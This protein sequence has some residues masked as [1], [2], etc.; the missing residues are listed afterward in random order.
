MIV[1]FIFKN[2]AG[3]RINCCEFSLIK[4]SSGQ[5]IGYNIDGATKN[6]PLYIDLNY[7]MAIFREDS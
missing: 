2:G 6:K 1:R 7:V 3:V 4:D 5:I